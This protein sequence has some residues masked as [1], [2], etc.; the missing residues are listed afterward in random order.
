[1]IKL[2]QNPDNTY[3]YELWIDNTL[4]SSRDGFSRW[5]D[6]L[7]FL[8]NVSEALG[9]FVSVMDLPYVHVYEED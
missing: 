6:I 1:M 4:I 2:K 7:D 5:E 3:K 8:S 9:R